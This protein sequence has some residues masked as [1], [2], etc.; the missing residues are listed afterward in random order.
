MQRFA[1]G[2]RYVGRADTGFFMGFGCRDPTVCLLMGRSSN[3]SWQN[4]TVVGIGEER[5]STIDHALRQ[6]GDHAVLVRS[7]E[8]S[9]D[10]SQTHELEEHVRHHRAGSVSYRVLRGRC[11]SWAGH[12]S[13]CLGRLMSCFLL[14]AGYFFL[15]QDV[16]ETYRKNSASSDCVLAEAVDTQRMIR[17]H[18]CRCDGEER[19]GR[20]Y[21]RPWV[22]ERMGRTVKRVLL[23]SATYSAQ[24]PMVWFL[25]L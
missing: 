10:R 24:I 18:W 20:K 2:R 4:A 25:P 9:S 11:R 8:P 3:R 14:C 13:I 23:D 12:N 19:A 1:G 6:W 16:A 15:I 17:S 7:I 5:G 21:L 22:R